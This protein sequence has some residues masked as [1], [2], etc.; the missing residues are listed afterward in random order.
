MPTVVAQAPTVDERELRAEAKRMNTNAY[1][2]DR[3]VATTATSGSAT[4][5]WIDQAARRHLS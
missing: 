1:F 4:G 2:V 3:R 5:D